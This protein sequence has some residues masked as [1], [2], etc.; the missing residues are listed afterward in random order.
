MNSGQGGGKRRDQLSTE[1]LVAQA[2]G[3]KAVQ[4]VTVKVRFLQLARPLRPAP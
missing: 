1:Y 2:L 3:I 4:V